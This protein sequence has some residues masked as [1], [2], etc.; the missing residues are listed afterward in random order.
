MHSE[1]SS[2]NSNFDND[3]ISLKELIFK[4]RE[5]YQF[6][7]TQWKLIILVS[8]IGGAI[9]YT[10][11]YRQPITYMATLTFALEEDN[12]GGGMSGAAGLASQF[13]FIPEL[14]QI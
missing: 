7:L 8:A 10:Y 6:L 14:I 12:G 11:A 2:N 9:G 1:N 4:I 3:E 13:G 5:W